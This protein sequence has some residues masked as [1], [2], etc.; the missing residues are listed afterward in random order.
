M[1]VPF[2][3]LRRT[4]RAMLAITT[5]ANNYIFLVV[6]SCAHEGQRWSSSVAFDFI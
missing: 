1:D 3:D 6:A 2:A 4:A 5:A